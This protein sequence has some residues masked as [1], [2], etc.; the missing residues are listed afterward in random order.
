MGS[1]G[2]YH[3]AEPFAL[4]FAYRTVPL[5]SVTRA[6]LKFPDRPRPRRLVR[7]GAPERRSPRVVGGA[8]ADVDARRIA[9]LSYVNATLAAIGRR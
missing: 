3:P 8:G 7:I 1:A 5:V 6:S 2:H 4:L 9:D